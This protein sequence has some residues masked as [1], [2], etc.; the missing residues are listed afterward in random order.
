MNIKKGKEKDSDQ[1]T[2]VK[3]IP[4][5]T[6]SEYCII[7]GSFSSLNNAEELTRKW[8][9]QGYKAKIIKLKN[10]SNS[11]L[12]AVASYESYD[13]ANEQLPVIKIKV[14]KDAWIYSLVISV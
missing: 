8:Q 9:K 6:R 3:K 10:N 4:H 1:T 14:A 7:I 5:N 12:V 2:D 13:K 11:L